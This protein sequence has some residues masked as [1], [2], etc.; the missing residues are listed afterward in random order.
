[1]EGSEWI[2]LQN[3]MFSSLLLWARYHIAGTGRSAA[4]V[5]VREVLLLDESGTIDNTF[6]AFRKWHVTCVFPASRGQWRMLAYTTT[7][8]DFLRDSIHSSPPPPLVGRMRSRASLSGNDCP[9]DVPG[10]GF[11]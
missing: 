4:L 2:Q 1:M 3:S 11:C 9:L 8:I 5:L 7:L 10:S 6:D